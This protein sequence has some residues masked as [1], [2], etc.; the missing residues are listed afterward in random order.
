MENL[1]YWKG[2]QTPPQDEGAS[3]HTKSGPSTPAFF[4][5]LV[6]RQAKGVVK[7]FVRDQCRLQAN[8]IV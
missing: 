8:P 2:L 6:V 4:N 5:R 3:E 1:N 7:I